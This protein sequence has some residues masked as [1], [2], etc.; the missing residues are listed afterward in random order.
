MLIPHDE[1]IDFKRSHYFILLST[2]IYLKVNILSN[3]NL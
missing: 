3:L 1:A 2:L